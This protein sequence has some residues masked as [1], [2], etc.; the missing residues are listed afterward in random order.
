MRRF[1]PTPETPEK[2][3]QETCGDGSPELVML[4]SASEELDSGEEVSGQKEAPPEEAL[5]RRLY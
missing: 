4:A 5:T 3:A 2:V 1:K